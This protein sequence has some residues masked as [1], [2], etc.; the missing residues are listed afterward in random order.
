LIVTVLAPA[1]AKIDGEIAR[2]YEGVLTRLEPVL[3]INLWV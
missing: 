3:D 2:K 1:H